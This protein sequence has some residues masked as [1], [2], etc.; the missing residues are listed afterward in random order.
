MKIKNKFLNSLVTSALSILPIILI[1]FILSWSNLTP[2]GKNESIT[3]AIGAVIMIFGLALFQIGAANGVA[4]VGEYMGASLS[5]QKRLWI[6]IIFAL[7]L[8][9]L[10]TCAEP[11]IMIISSQIQIPKFLLIGFIAGGVGIF[12]VVGIIRIFLGKSLKLWYLIFYFITFA[13][14]TLLQS[15]PDIVTS[16]VDYLPFIFDAGGITTGS[17]TVPFILALGAGFATVKGGKRA[18]EDSFGLVGMASIGPI[19]SMIVLLL[20]RRSGFQPFVLDNWASSDSVWVRFKYA[21]LFESGT[22]MG[23]LIDVLL[24]LAPIIIV[25]TIYELIFIKLPKREVGR[26]AIGFLFAYVG[27]VLFLTGVNASMSPVGNSVGM[28]LATKPVA[29]FILAFV[30]GC[31]TILCEPAVHS[32]T[33]QIEITSAGSIKKLIVLI[34]LS[35]GVGIA[36]LLAAI[37]TYYKFSIMYYVVPGYAISLILMFF[38][39]NLFAA[40]AFDSGGTASGPMSVSFVVPMMV[41]IT[42]YRHAITDSAWQAL[43]EEAK[44]LY[45]TYMVNGQH[46]LLKGTEFY[47]E[48]FGVVA[49]IALMPIIAIQVLGIISH[50]KQSYRLKAYRNLVH[51]ESNGRIINL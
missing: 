39:P 14:I 45:T 11:S 33:R 2:I 34:T 50:A 17:A 12:V 31:V 27:L 10:I 32:L 19:I 6:V 22:H 40:I 26:L 5:K 37:R 30:I 20:V 46:C 29:L 43:S 18:S 42:S 48:S 15:I 51:N 13:I 7:L 3:L 25:F 1:I 36:V 9:A 16:G 38:T 8:G 44:A 4:K 41:G 23:S 24:A 21:L 28:Q 35:A 47:G 49:L